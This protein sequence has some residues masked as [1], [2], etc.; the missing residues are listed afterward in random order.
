MYVPALLF[1]MGLLC[2]LCGKVKRFARPHLPI[3]DSASSAA[4][5][6]QTLVT[7]GGLDSSTIESYPKTIFGESQRL[8]KRNDSTCAICLSENKTKEILRSIPECQHCFHAECVDQWLKLKSSCPVC[9]NSP[10][11][12]SVCNLVSWG[13]CLFVFRCN[14]NFCEEN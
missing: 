10:K 2:C 7:T 5:V 13:F 9:R 6:P 14:W 12:T 3:A 1:V 11:C 4:V 8:P